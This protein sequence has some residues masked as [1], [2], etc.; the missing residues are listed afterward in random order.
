MLD[1]EYTDENER[2]WID[3]SVRH[4]ASSTDSDVAR[5]ARRGG[6]AARRGERCKH[7]RYPGAQ[8]T[9]F[10]VEVNGR[11][12]GEARQWIRQQVLR[13]PADEHAAEQTRAYQAVSCSLQ[14]QLARQRRAAAGLR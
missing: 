6:E 4:A 3:V 2:R 10:V 8:L 12:G 1:V 11:L 9:A 14:T 7:D 13:L 5:A